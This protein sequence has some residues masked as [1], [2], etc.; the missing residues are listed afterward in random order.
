M[1]LITKRDRIK[2]V[3]ERWKKQYFNYGD[4]VKLQNID[5]KKYMIN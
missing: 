3:A 5:S 1:E 4:W 2:S